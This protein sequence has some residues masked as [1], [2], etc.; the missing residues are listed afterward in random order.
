M[1]APFLTIITR[2]MA[3]RPGMFA[4]QQVSLAA[5]SCQ[6]FE[7]VLIHDGVGQGM[8]W[9]QTQLTEAWKQANGRYILILDDDDLLQNPD[10][11]KLLKEAAYKFPPAVIFKG[12]H[13]DLGILPRVDTWQSA[14]QVGSIG[15]FDFIL[16]WDVFTRHSKVFAAGTYND[17]HA[18]IAS[19]YR[20]H[21]KDI[22]WLDEVI[23][24]VQRRS[25]GAPE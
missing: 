4:K 5:Q 18:L 14:P 8:A 10:G 21:G 13:D 20:E 3:S 24:A 2:H 12:H 1:A 16:R 25:L 9:A 19:V 22:V 6:D 17:D 15:V 7:Q 23:C 11:V